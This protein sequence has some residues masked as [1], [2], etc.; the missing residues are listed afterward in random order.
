MSLLRE[1]QIANWSLKGCAPVD[2]CRKLFYHGKIIY[3]LKALHAHFKMY[4]SVA[5]R[6]LTTL[7]SHHH[8][9]VPWLLHHPRQ[10]ARPREA[11]HLP[12]ANSGCRKPPFLYAGFEVLYFSFQASIS[13]R[14]TPFK[15]IYKFIYW[16]IYFPS[17]SIKNFGRDCYHIWIL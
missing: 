2:L 7:Y 15:S 4:D 8:R 17:R 3:H 9:L 16:P 6:I 11:P 12:P 13:Y 10:K 1:T 14:S 5:S